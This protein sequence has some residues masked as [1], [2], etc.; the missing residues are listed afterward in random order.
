MATT[1][2][3]GGGIAEYAEI[4]DTANPGQVKRP[5]A[6]QV[7]KVRDALTQVALPDITTTDY[8]YLN[9]W[10]AS[11]PLVEVSGD[12]GVTWRGPLVGRE[13]L[14]EALTA[15]STAATAL[16]VATSADTKASQALA[17]SSSAGVTINGFGPASTFTSAQMGVRGTS[18]PIPS[19]AVTG[20]SPVSTSGLARDL[21]DY[22]QP[23]GVPTLGL[24]GK[25][26][27]AQIGGGAGGGVLTIF[28]NP[29]GS[30]PSRSTVTTDATR[31]VEWDPFYVPTAL[32]KIAAD[33]VG[34]YPANPALGVP[35]DRTIRR[36]A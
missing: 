7:V 2:S 11:T 16:Q 17:A 1:N 34:A 25:I 28:Q 6:G 8:G 31:R 22:G 21:A 3:F 13:S 20:L 4:V 5:P 15:G 9:T 24:D 26:P 14:I 33:G 10:T 12:G 18:D 23:G 29:D 36:G 30:W 35:G 32:P 27:A 19:S